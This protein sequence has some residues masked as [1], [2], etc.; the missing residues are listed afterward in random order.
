M[1]RHAWLAFVWIVLSAGATL[2]QQTTVFTYQGQLTDAGQPA[3]GNF[4]LQ[5]ALFD[6]TSAGTQIGSTLTRASVAVSGGVFTVQLDFGVSAFPGAN[7]FLEIGVRPSGGGSFTTLAPRQQISSTPYAIRTLSAAS[8]DALS[9]AC[10]GCVT[11]AQIG[12]VA[13]S[14]V[15][16]TIPAASVPTGSGNYVQNTTAQQ[17]N[18]NFNISGN[19]TVGQTLSGGS[20][21]AGPAVQFT[22]QLD[23]NGTAWIRGDST[24]LTGHG[25]GLAAG[26][27]G[28]SGYLFAFD[29]GS[30]APLNL[31]LN[32][33]GGN[34]GVGT[35]TPTA[36]LQVDGNGGDGVHAT[37]TGGRGVW[38]DSGT[39]Q[40]V[41]GHSTSNAGVVGE[42]DMFDGVFAVSHDPN[43][44][45]VYATNDNSGF[46]VTGITNA[47]HTTT[48]AGVYGQSTGSGG[49][50]VIGEAD[51]GNAWGVYGTSTSPTGVGVYG[52]SPS[53]FAMAAAGD[54]QQSRDKGGWVKAMVYVKLD[55]T[56]ARCYNSQTALPGNCAAGATTCCGI[57][58]QHP[59]LGRYYV[60][61]GFVVTDRFY[62][63]E[64]INTGSELDVYAQLYPPGTALSDGVPSP[65]QLLILMSYVGNQDQTDSPF[66]I[67][68]F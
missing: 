44:S 33:P 18:A 68:V 13:G 60:D 39:Y 24:P 57:T 67:V 63:I 54:V 32:S 58:V 1:T 50:G 3:N 15:T 46:G 53:G 42:S 52:S 56:I 61:F 31:L 30:A 22:P 11:N 45:G 41:Y 40:G 17:P 36:R 37:S 14:K 62:S 35:A 5:F 28:T 8:A 43:N 65:N 38:G 47:A 49:V 64:P 20:V 26:F 59:H 27:N 55:G 6:N 34:V 25:K 19:G 9:S 29:Y 2:G 48:K 7:R 10:V 12:S 16:G 21:A 66:V 23:V 4:D 51:S